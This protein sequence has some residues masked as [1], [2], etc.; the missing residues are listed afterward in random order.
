MV[1]MMHKSVLLEESIAA[2][3]IK[4]DGTYVDCT[5][6]Y[7]GHSSQILKRIKKGFLFAFDQD[8][9]AIL[10]SEKKLAGI[11]SNYKIIYANF[12]DLKKNINTEVDG[13]LYDL[14]VSSPQLDEADR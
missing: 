9:E 12:K 4:E 7:A 5:L 1:I 10:A 11:G 3:Q 13:I 14:G 6:G 2:L 8:Q